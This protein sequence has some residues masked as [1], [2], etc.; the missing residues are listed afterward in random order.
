MKNLLLFLLTGLMSL[1]LLA[2]NSPCTPDASLQDSLFGLWPDTIQNLPLAYVDQYYEEHIQIKIPGTVGEVMGSPFYLPGTF[3]DIST[4]GIDSIKLI[5]IEGLPNVMSTYISNPDSIFVGNTIGCLTLYGTP[6]VNEIGQHDITIYIDGWVTAPVIGVTSLYD[7][8]GSYES[9]N[10]YKLIVQQGMSIF[11][12]Q[13][14]SFVVSQNFPNPSSDL[15]QF[16][17]Q[18]KETKAYEFKILNLLGESIFQDQLHLNS[19]LNTYHFDAT[20][21]NSGIYFYSLS[22][23]QIVSTKK[24]IVKH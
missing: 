14:S 22:D 2:Q 11:E 23:G 9:I 4:L 10:G 24:M 7:Q 6:G 20:H 5:S 8:L 19:G 12:N 17:I 13:E 3:I 21:L 18:S 15:T 1:N 16:E